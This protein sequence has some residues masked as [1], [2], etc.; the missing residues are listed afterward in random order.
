MKRNFGEAKLTT[1]ESKTPRTEQTM[2]PHVKECIDEPME[3]TSGPC[4]HDIRDRPVAVKS[5]KTPRRNRKVVRSLNT[6]YDSNALHLLSQPSENFP[7]HVV[8]PL[9]SEDINKFNESWSRIDKDAIISQHDSIGIALSEWKDAFPSQQDRAHIITKSFVMILLQTL[10][11]DLQSDIVRKFC[12][13]CKAIEEETATDLNEDVFSSINRSLKKIF[14]NV[15]SEPKSTKYIQLE[16]MNKE[17]TPCLSPQDSRSIS[18]SSDVE[19][20]VKTP[21]LT[22]VD[23]NEL[24][25]KLRHCIHC[26]TDMGRMKASGTCSDCIWKAHK[27]TTN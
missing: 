23:P 2:S 22:H 26:G 17:N 24:E 14:V 3:F 15:I 25:F 16:D 4:K 20:E 9:S 19:S 5:P 18:E 13:F 27:T 7:S 12:N 6:Q 10:P 11:S 8:V 1:P 21:L